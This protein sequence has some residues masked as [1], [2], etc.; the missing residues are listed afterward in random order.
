MAPFLL[1]I[2]FW[3]CQQ[4]DISNK[5][6]ALP[7]TAFNHSVKDF[8]SSITSVF[9]HTRFIVTVHFDSYSCK[10]MKMVMINQPMRISVIKGCPF[11]Y[12]MVIDSTLILVY[13]RSFQ[14]KQDSG[15]SDVDD[16]LSIFPENS[17]KSDWD[18]VNKES[19]EQITYN[20]MIKGYEI[21]G[22][23]FSIFTPPHP[24]SFYSPCVP[25]P[26]SLK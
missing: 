9:G 18:A 23:S 13:M 20:S 21:N 15:N 12:Y 8:I 2:F 7:T 16:I 17:F 4:G 14:I 10:G 22:D 6:L 24:S 3:A 11:D 5:N 26:L 1:I 25:C 19:T